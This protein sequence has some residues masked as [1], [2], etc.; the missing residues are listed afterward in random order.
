MQPPMMTTIA[1]VPS[2]RRTAASARASTATTTM[3]DRECIR[4]LDGSM[5]SR[6]IRHQSSTQ[7]SR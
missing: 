6:R 1:A 7:I 3:S 2:S 4:K 5:P